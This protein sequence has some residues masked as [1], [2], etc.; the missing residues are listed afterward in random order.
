MDRF[1]SYHYGEGKTGDGQHVTFTCPTDTA[2]EEVQEILKNKFR[3]FDI[4]SAHQVNVGHGAY[5]M[6]SRY[7]IKQHK[8]AGGGPND[9]GNWG[10]IEV[11]EIKNPP[12]G[13]CGI[14]IHECNS[15]TGAVFTEWATLTDANK[16]FKKNWLEEKTNVVFPL[17]PG[18]KRR[19]VCGLMTPWF[20]A[21]GDQEL[22]G[23]FTFPEG[24]QNDPK[25][26]LGQRFIIEDYSGDLILKTCLGCRH[27]TIKET[28][29]PYT[30]HCYRIV[31]WDD[32]TF[33]DDKS[34]SIGRSIR[35]LRDDELWIDEAI[36]QFHRLLSGKSK[37]F[38][39]NFTD[40]SKFVGVLK[41]TSEQKDLPTAE[42]RYYVVVH[43]K[44]VTKAKKGWV[45]FKPNLV[46]SNL[47]K[48]ITLK[49][50]DQGKDIERIKVED[51][52][53]TRGGKK[54][55]GVFYS[56]AESS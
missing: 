52:V 44:G 10:F 50:K 3:D 40:G 34:G 11:L 6:Y 17:S 47:F 35:P 32:G 25:Y 2:I 41:Q 14:V 54:W 30:E 37:N 39:I 48:H 27:Y 19:V 55:S 8:Y 42:G 21:V 56:S 5:G 31:Q 53:V 51:Q 7:K 18:F 24:L 28:L 1:N 9:G 29:H 13:R 22:F 49:F 20:Y 15:C 38:T 4:P 12:D 23:D 46:V 16:A 45:D 43:I 33:W 36:Q 26:K